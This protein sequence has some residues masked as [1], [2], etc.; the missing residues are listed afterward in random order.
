MLPTQ[1]FP[2][3]LRWFKLA[4]TKHIVLGLYCQCAP[5]YRHSLWGCQTNRPFAGWLPWEPGKTVD[6]FK[7]LE[8]G[9][10]KVKQFFKAGTLKIDSCVLSFEE[11]SSENCWRNVCHGLKG[12]S[13]WVCAG[14]MCV[15]IYIYMYPMHV[16]VCVSATSYF[17]HL[18][19]LNDKWCDVFLSHLHSHKAYS[20]VNKIFHIT[21][22]IT[23]DHLLDFVMPPSRHSDSFLWLKWIKLELFS[24]CR[25]EK[26]LVQSV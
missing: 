6:E 22:N 15:S 9:S 21:W 13:W 8:A 1:Q 19:L 5:P 4:C 10:P 24:D 3:K 12:D 2:R 20:Y 17:Q 11:R 26:V 25:V 16:C 18:Q 23:S 14:G 7:R